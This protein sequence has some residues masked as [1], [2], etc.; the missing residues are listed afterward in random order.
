MTMNLHI[1]ANADLYLVKGALKYKATLKHAQ[2]IGGTGIHEV[3]S[4]L[5]P[6]GETA[7]CFPEFFF[8]VL[9]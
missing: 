1:K 6:T 5:A 7:S 3:L 8:P 4:T 9:K 2:E